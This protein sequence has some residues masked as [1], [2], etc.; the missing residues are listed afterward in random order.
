MLFNAIANKGNECSIKIGE[1]RCFSE[2]ER[3]SIELSGGFG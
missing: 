2:S 1:E 3:F